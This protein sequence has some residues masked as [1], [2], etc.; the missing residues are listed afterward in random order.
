MLC[1]IRIGKVHAM[2]EGMSLRQGHPHSTGSHDQWQGLEDLSNDES[3]SDGG[4]TSSLVR[5]VSR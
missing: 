4:V 5:K 3:V 1:V 2:V